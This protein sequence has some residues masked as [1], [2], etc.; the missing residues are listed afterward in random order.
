MTTQGQLV[1]EVAGWTG[2]GRHI[3]TLSYGEIL[4]AAVYATVSL[5]DETGK[6]FYHLDLTRQ[7]QLGVRY[8]RRQ[9]GVYHIVVYSAESGPHRALQPYGEQPVVQDQLLL[10]YGADESPGRQAGRAATRFRWKQPEKQPALCGIVLIDCSGRLLAVKI[11]TKPVD[12]PRW[13]AY[14][15]SWLSR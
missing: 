5:V 12:P 13:G 4:Q 1:L 7:L 9:T 11:L 10:M 3:T 8:Q 15:K 6:E 14:I 2:S